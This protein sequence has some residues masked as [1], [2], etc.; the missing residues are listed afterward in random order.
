[1]GYEDDPVCEI[2]DMFSPV[3]F[4]TLCMAG[5]FQLQRQFLKSCKAKLLE[6]DAGDVTECIGMVTHAVVRVQ[7]NKVP[8]E[9]LY[10]LI[11]LCGKEEVQLLIST[12]VC[13][14]DSMMQDVNCTQIRPRG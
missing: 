6:E 12:I 11:H 7:L 2:G 9:S 8:E 10:Q 1:V 14:S 13:C 3:Y 5:F 4:C